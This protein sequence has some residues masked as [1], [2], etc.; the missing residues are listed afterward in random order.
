MAHTSQWTPWPLVHVQGRHCWGGKQ[1]EVLSSV[2][3]PSSTL[4]HLWKVNKSTSELTNAFPSAVDFIIMF[5][6]TLGRLTQLQRGEGFILHTQAYTNAYIHSLL[7]PTLTP[8]WQPQEVEK[9][10]FLPFRIMAVIDTHRNQK[11]MEMS[12]K[13]KPVW[14]VLLMQC[15]GPEVHQ[16]PV[17]TFSL[18]SCTQILLIPWIFQ[19]Y[20][21]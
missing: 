9:K 21:L 14:K 18:G 5:L 4:L 10:E 20:S 15:W 7:S 13:E 1:S 6:Y 12:H 17:L 11:K 3:L 19:Y 16:H 8:F 2:H